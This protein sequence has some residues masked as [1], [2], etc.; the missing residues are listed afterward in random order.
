MCLLKMTLEDLLL[1]PNMWTYFQNFGCPSF[2]DTIVRSK[3]ENLENQKLS[4][5]RYVPLQGEL[6]GHPFSIDPWREVLGIGN[7]SFQ[8]SSISVAQILLSGQ[9]LYHVRMLMVIQ[10]LTSFHHNHSIRIIEIKTRTTRQKN[11]TIFL[12]ETTREKTQQLILYRLCHQV[13]CQ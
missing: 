6:Y 4:P 11:R 5:Q 7:P 8:L 10:Y 13:K 9:L 2:L 3:I 1:F 12:Q